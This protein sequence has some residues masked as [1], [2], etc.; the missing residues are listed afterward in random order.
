MSIVG[1]LL[2]EFWPQIVG[3]IAALGGMVIVFMAGGSRANNKHEKRKA[4]ADA[5][6]HDRINQVTPA[7]PVDR[8]DVDERLSRL[9][10]KR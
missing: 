6:T 5:K 2:G 10:G 3:G 4:K 1:V 7:D 8:I 9:R